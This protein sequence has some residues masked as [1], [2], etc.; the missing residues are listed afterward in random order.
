MGRKT[1]A[2]FQ[3][4]RALKLDPSPEDKARIEAKMTSGPEAVLLKKAESDTST[5]LAVARRN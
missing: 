5:A 3:W 1:E 2:R 4:Q